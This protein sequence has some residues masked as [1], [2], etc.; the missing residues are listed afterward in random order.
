MNQIRHF[1]LI[2]TILLASNAAQAQNIQRGDTL[3]LTTW[4][5][6]AGVTVRI[7]GITG[8][9]TF[10]TTHTPNSD[11][12]SAT[13][14]MT[15]AAGTLKTGVLKHLTIVVTAGTVLRGQL[16]ARVELIRT[17]TLA[18]FLQSYVSSEMQLS[19]PPWKI[20]SSIEGPGVIRS[21]TGTN[22]AAGAGMIETVPTGAIW[23]FISMNVTLVTDAN[24]GARNAHFFFD[25]GTTIYL[26]CTNDQGQAEN[27]TQIYSVANGIHMGFASPDIQSIP[28]PS[29]LYLPAGHRIREGTNNFQAGDDWG[30]PQLLVEEW[31]LP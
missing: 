16:F 13:T 30:A 6:V 28:C 26:R 23:R 3:R 25:D 8:S 12:T 5:S 20:E 10:S 18:T 15:V 27:L 29:N 14:N 2:I 7:S 19:G 9:G 21:I 22:P 17:N 4:G 31:I 11:R 24:V 1:F